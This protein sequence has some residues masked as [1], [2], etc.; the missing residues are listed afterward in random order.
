VNIKNPHAC[1]FAY[2]DFNG[3]MLSHNFMSGFVKQTLKP[4]KGSAARRHYTMRRGS[5][6]K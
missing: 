5:A 6:G 4:W 3:S 2:V 1:F